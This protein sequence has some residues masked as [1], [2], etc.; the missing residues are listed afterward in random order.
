MDE[1]SYKV[2]YIKQVGRNKE[3][4]FCLEE[5]PA[6][7]PF[8]YTFRFDI[9]EEVGLWAST[10]F[11]DEVTLTFILDSTNHMKKFLDNE[12]LLALL[13][14]SS[15]LSLKKKQDNLRHEIENIF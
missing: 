10:T 13:I 3:I 6:L 1:Q 12:L 4:Q 2:A 14:L 15:R 11:D 9:G 8:A 5:M 7:P